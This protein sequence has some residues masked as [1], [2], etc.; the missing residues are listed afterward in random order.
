MISSVILI[1]IN[2]INFFFIYSEKINVFWLI[3]FLIIVLIQNSIHIKKRVVLNET[4][5]VYG[6]VSRISM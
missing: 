4:E 5:R 3:N 2:L 1:N 6:I